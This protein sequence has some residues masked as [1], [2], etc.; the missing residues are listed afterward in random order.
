MISIINLVLKWVRKLLF[1]WDRNNNKMKTIIAGTRTIEAYDA[2]K[3]AIEES[4]FDITMVVSGV[5]RGV[6]K[7]GERW[8]KENTVPVNPFPADWDNI[9]HPDAVIKTNRYGKKYDA[10]AG[11][12]RN[13]QM[14]EY[15]DALI[16]IWD[17][18]SPGTKNMIETAERNGLS[19][20]EVK[21]K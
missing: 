13:K 21:I 11:H 15:A 1:I 2:V 6:D 18:F 3:N 4:G 17:G 12:R 20:H 9:T 14:A 7:L 5:C 16:V 19:I 8:A 10:K